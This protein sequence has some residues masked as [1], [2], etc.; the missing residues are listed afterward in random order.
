LGT[1]FPAEEPAMAALAVR[2]VKFFDIVVVTLLFTA[3]T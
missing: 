2:S 3:F 1:T